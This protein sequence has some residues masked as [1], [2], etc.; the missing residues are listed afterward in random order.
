M[1]NLLENF[2]GA[3]WLASLTGLACYFLFTGLEARPGEEPAVPLRSAAKDVARIVSVRPGENGRVVVT[4]RDREGATRAL[5]LAPEDA[6]DSMGRL[7]DTD[8]LASVLREF[9]DSPF[10]AEAPLDDPEALKAWLLRQMSEVDR[11]P[12]ADYPTWFRNPI[13]QGVDRFGLRPATSSARSS[14]P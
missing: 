6:A 7:S 3:A 10:L 5:D 12:A 11:A 14:L 2:P 8:D 1:K 13:V 9:A 4:Y